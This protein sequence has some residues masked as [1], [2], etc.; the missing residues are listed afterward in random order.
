MERSLNPQAHEA[1]RRQMNKKRKNPGALVPHPRGGRSAGAFWDYEHSL[2]LQSKGCVG[3]SSAKQGR[4]VLRALPR[5]AQYMSMSSTQQST[6]F[7]PHPPLGE[8]RGW[9]QS[10]TRPGLD[11]TWSLS[12]SV[13]LSVCLSLALSGSAVSQQ[14]HCLASLIP[15]MMPLA[16]CGGVAQKRMCEEGVRVETRTSGVS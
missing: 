14:R 13:S 15:Q 10:R 3:Q 4:Q 7:A 16:G 12:L 1:N 5:C 2:Y 9:G 8:G 11:L 6:N